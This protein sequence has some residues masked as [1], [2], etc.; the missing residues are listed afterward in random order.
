MGYTAQDIAHDAFDDT[1]D[2]DDILYCSAL[3]WPIKLEGS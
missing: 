1:L 3:D 2:L